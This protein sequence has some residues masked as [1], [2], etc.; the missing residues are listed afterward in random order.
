[1]D[2]RVATE[3]DPL[4]R[5]D[6]LLEQIREVMLSAESIGPNRVLVIENETRDDLERSVETLS[7]LLYTEAA[8]A[9]LAGSA[10]VEV[11]AKECL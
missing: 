4:R 9:G 2:N 1:M 6:Q 8:K 7:Q 3:S 10:R 5:S 11:G